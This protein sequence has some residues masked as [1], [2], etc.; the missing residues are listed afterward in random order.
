MLNGHPARCCVAGV[1]LVLA[2][3]A[4][5]AAEFLAPLTSSRIEDAQRQADLAF[6]SGQ[7]S[8]ARSIYLDTLAPAGDKY[9]QYVLGWMYFKGI[10]V[11]RDLVM[12][13]AWL[14]LAAERGDVQFKKVHDQVLAQ[15]DPADREAVTQQ[16]D[17]LRA[18]YG[19]CAVTRSL[20][21]SEQQM[22]ER[23]TGSRLNGNESSPVFVIDYGTDLSS[24]DS[25]H[26]T[27]TQVRKSVD[28]RQRFLR[29]YCPAAETPPE[30]GEDPSP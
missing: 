27:Q 16:A 1:V 23:P 15:V 5:S 2:A 10:G 28:R 24:R 30:A 12:G 21:A 20:L 11:D 29:R 3:G 22:I 26:I 8:Q 7:Y 13:A 9:A 6:K 18:Q 17:A 4:A 19:D 25:D 14:E